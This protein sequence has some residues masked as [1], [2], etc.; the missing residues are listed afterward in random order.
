[1]GKRIVLCF[2]GTWNKP[3]SGSQPDT[4]N[5]ASTNVWKF[6]KS[7]L[8]AAPDNTEQVSYYDSGVGTD[9][10]GGFLHDWFD[11]ILG[12][13]FGLGLDKKIKDGYRFLASHYNDG[14]HVFILGFSRGAYTA[15]SLVGLIRNAGL[16]PADRL[17]ETDEAYALYRKRDDGPDVGEAKRFRDTNGS[18]LIPIHFLGVWDT[19]GALG[20]PLGICKQLDQD[21]YGFHDT[22]LSSL[23]RNAFQAL[24]IDEHRKTFAANLWDP[25]AK[26]AQRMEQRWF[27]G[28]HS[29]VGGGYDDDRLSDIAL[30]WMMEHAEGCGLAIDPIWVPEV[31][32][33][34]A[35]GVI[36]DS[37]ARFLDGV[38]ELVQPRHYR[39]VCVLPF[40]EENLHESVPQRAASDAGYAPP[41]VGYRKALAQFGLPP[42]QQ[43]APA[44]ASTAAG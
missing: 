18:T 8:G 34:N 17:G 15:R 4:D 33:D 24:A 26:P 30:K 35:L 23:V 9:E 2:D 1:M 44:P 7:V 25:K 41:N 22:E 5:E 13:A 42:V 27:A 6:Y 10:K 43:P 12:G 36:V 19:V 32:P 40:S 11:K 21:L 14:D 16:L 3:G 37:Y 20:V 28:C 39:P 31:S 38:G 29:N